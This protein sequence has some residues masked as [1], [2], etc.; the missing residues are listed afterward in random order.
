MTPDMAWWKGAGGS[1]EVSS[2][3]IAVAS[4]EEGVRGET[5]FHRATE[6]E[7]RE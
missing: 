7:A 3:V 6:P 2:F 5:W 1:R 4:L